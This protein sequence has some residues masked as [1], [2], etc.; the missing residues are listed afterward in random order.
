MCGVAGLF[1]FKSAFASVAEARSVVES[2][3]AT[4]AHRGPDDAGLW[5]DPEGRCVLGHRRLSII[6]TSEAGHQPMTDA[7]GR[8]T[9]SFNGELYNFQELRTP[10][11]ECVHL[12]GRTDTEVLLGALSTWGTDAL[13]KF[14]GMFAFAAFDRES[15]SLLLARDPFGEKPLYTMD[16]PDGGI[17]FASELQAL[18][19]VPGFDGRVSIDAVAELLSFQYIGAPRSIYENVRKLPP[20]H[21]LRAN[22]DGRRE[23]GRYF[24]FRPGEQGFDAGDANHLVDVLEELL[25]RSTR[26]RLISDVPLGAFLS[27]G[28]DSST[29]CAL[30]RR[31]LNLPLMTFSIGFEQAP[32]SEHEAARSFAAHLGT[33]HH[34]HIVAPHASEFLRRIGGLLDEPNADSSCLPTYLLSEFARTHVTVAV[35]GDGGDELFGGYGRYFSTLEDASRGG[36]GKRQVGATYYSNRILV[37][38]EEHLAELFGELPTGFTTHLADLRREIDEG[39]TPLHCRLRRTDVDNYMPGAVLPKVDRMSMRHSLEV[40]TPFLNVELARF[41]ERLPQNRLI[42]GQQG[43]LLLRQLAYRYLPRDLVDRPKQGF[44]LPMSRWGRD[45]LLNVTAELLESDDSRLAAALGRPAIAKFMRRQRSAGGFSTYQVWAIATLESWLRQHPASLPD[46]D[47]GHRS[48]A[49]TARAMAP[50][51][52]GVAERRFLLLQAERDSSGPAISDQL[53][54]RASGIAKACGLIAPARQVRGGTGEVIPLPVLSGL[55]SGPPSPTIAALEGAEIIVPQS[56]VAGRWITP[57]R[58]EQFKDSGV[59]VL[60][61]PHPDGHPGRLVAVRMN[62]L[63]HAQ[64]LR[65]SLALRAALVARWPGVRG[66]SMDGNVY[67]CEVGPLGSAAD[68]EAVCEF[69]LFSDGR[70]HPP[71]PCS[72]SEIAARG[73]G[74][75]SVWSDACWFSS[76]DNSPPR[77]RYRLVRRTAR[78]EALVEYLARV[79]EGGDMGRAELLAAIS[80]QVECARGVRPPALQ[81]G[82]RVAVVTHSLPP[83]GAERQWCYLAVGLKDAGYEVQMLCTEVLAGANAHYLPLLQQAGIPVLQCSEVDESE[84]AAVAFEAERGV[85]FLE[86]ESDPLGIDVLRLAVLLKKSRP[87]AVFAQLDS[88][89]IAAGVA[90]H[91]ADV[92]VAVLSFRNYNPSHFSY[93]RNDWY[94]PCYQRLATSDR[95]RLSGNSSLANDD[96]A[97]WI[98]VAHRSVTLVPNC[99]EEADVAGGGEE[100]V[101]LLRRDLGLAEDTPVVLGVFRLSEEKDPR[102]FI[103]ACADIRKQLPD[104]RALLV[105]EGPMRPELQGRIDELGLTGA[106]SLLGRRHDVPDLMRLATLLLLTSRHEGMPNVAMEAQ[107]LGLPVVGTAVG[108]TPDAV[109]DGQTGFLRPAGDVQGLAQACVRILREPALRAQFADSARRH[110]RSHFSRAEMVQRY[111]D[112]ATTSNATV[113]AA[114]ETR[115]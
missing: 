65:R 89:N 69:H 46:W 95:I 75:Y 32:E 34:E 74:R 33:E 102:A 22:A 38:T 49:S 27:G 67:Q 23:T 101:A 86:P 40:R 11:G 60:A 52:V 47:S 39:S 5:A 61:Y 50:V 56:E 63:D 80:R 17:A 45:A 98:G 13:P 84:A 35:S 10:V 51:L 108:G 112:L 37:S 30:V 85:V 82:A 14:D 105:G 73:G 29:V 93:L 109:V 57:R 48:G 99:I 54:A 106:L 68:T 107:M 55:Q 24:A 103:D 41:A 114:T 1:R 43:K 21:W 59:R 3:T 111:V 113:R 79:V 78:N 31:D 97:D 83:G 4:I 91:L 58:V 96:Y 7:A 100:H 20:G 2:M 92:P 90:A 81:P 71:L 15:G 12:K 62:R 26:R 28:V 110:G 72:H 64:R 77:G 25:V 36:F 16:L 70:Q 104:V 19:R 44:G 8:W 53:L 88:T 76:F 18:E 42:A 87:E 9:I 6:D 66:H 94:L 115:P